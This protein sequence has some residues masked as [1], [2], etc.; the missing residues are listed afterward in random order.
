MQRNDGSGKLYKRDKTNVLQ[1][2]VEICGDDNIL[3]HLEPKSPLP[4]VT[5]P[6]TSTEYT[7]ICSKEVEKELIESRS[8]GSTWI[9]N[10]DENMESLV[11]FVPSFSDKTATTLKDTLLVAF[12]VHTIFLNESARRRKCLINDRHTPVG[13]LP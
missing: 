2:Q 4:Q 5:S 7:G 1:E 8:S 13:F 3:L 11:G 9:E 10:R 12:L 6:T